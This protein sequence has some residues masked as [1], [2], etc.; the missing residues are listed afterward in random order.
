[1]TGQPHMTLLPNDHLVVNQFGEQDFAS[2]LDTTIDLLTHDATI[3]PVQFPVTDD[4]R[5]FG[6]RR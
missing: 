4:L 6:A 3:Q 1:M 5:N 2:T